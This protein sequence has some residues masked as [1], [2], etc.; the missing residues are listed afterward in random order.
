MSLLDGLKKLTDGKK[1]FAGI[2]IA[3]VPTLAG[4][5]GYAVSPEDIAEG[6]TLLFSVVD[7]LEAFCVAV[8]GLLAWYGR[9][10]AKS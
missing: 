8:G 1:T 2:A 3:V 6:G 5:F 4:F 9:A 7:E 10:V